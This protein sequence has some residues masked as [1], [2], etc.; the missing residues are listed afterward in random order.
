MDLSLGVGVTLEA[1][2]DKLAQADCHNSHR[3]MCAP[4]VEDL[5]CMPKPSAQ[6]ES[7]PAETVAKRAISKRNAG[8]AG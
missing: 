6:P 3:R 7:K 4:D 5:Q 2:G 1:K 8:L